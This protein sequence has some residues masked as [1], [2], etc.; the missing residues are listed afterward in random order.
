MTPFG[1]SLIAVIFTALLPWTYV[2]GGRARLPLCLSVLTLALDTVLYYF[3]F[4]HFPSITRGLAMNI[5]LMGSLHV[6]S[7]AL[8]GLVWGILG[9]GLMRRFLATPT[10]LLL[11]LLMG[12]LYALYLA[13]NF[14]SVTS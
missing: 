9:Q 14:T 3:L 4:F 13:L 5:F 8:S 7:I 2:F 11:V 6:L 12:R 10:P 1:L